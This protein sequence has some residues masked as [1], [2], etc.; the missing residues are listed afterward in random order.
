LVRRRSFF[1]AHEKAVQIRKPNFRKNE[2][3][4]LL[5]EHDA[6]RGSPPRRAS[7]QSGN[8]HEHILRSAVGSDLDQRKVA[9]RV[10]DPIRS[11][12]KRLTAGHEIEVDLDDDRL[13]AHA[14]GTSGRR[15]EK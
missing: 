2:L 9:R 6:R 3:A 15:R 5:L 4:R 10:G 7:R 12:W 13:L 8:S 11:G 1:A 14:V